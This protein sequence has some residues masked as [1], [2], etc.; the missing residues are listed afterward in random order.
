MPKKDIKPRSAAVGKHLSVSQAADLQDTNATRPVFS[1]Q[2][3]QAGCCIADCDAQQKGAF[4]DALHELSQ[5]TWREITVASRQGKGLE[6]L[7]RYAIRKP[8]PDS[9]KDDVTT[10]IGIR[11]WD[12]R[13]MVGYRDRDVFHII[14]LD[15]NGDLYDHGR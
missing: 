6:T 11:F 5:M 14:W 1:L 9:I 2:Y 7:K 10:L 8:I 15:I 3:M 4:A 12:K 13:R